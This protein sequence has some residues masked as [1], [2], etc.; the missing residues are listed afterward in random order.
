M[1]VSGSRTN[2]YRVDRMSYPSIHI[3]ELAAEMIH[4]EISLS[5]VQNPVVT[6]AEE[7]D[8][9]RPNT[10]WRE[11]FFSGADKDSLSKLFLSLHGEQMENIGKKI[12]INVISRDEIPK[13]YEIFIIEISEFAILFPFDE[14]KPSVRW[15]L[16]VGD[17]GLV[18]TADGD[19]VLPT[20]KRGRSP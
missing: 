9:I 8:F 6:L 17:N 12:I 3:S 19:V 4:T 14:I 10:E 2:V 15:V 7:S 11:A 20:R 1:K 16:D 18:L 5:N 13:E